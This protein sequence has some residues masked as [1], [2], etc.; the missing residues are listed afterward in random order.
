MAET[1]QVTLNSFRKFLE[2]F[3]PPGRLQNNT[4]P[5]YSCACPEGCNDAPKFPDIF[6]DLAYCVSFYVNAAVIPASAKIA[7][8]VTKGGLRFTVKVLRIYTSFVG[9]RDH[10]ISPNIPPH[11]S[12]PN[13]S[14]S[15]TNPQN[16][17]GQ[18]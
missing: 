3:V 14:A 10:E 16:V 7:R 8:L 2:L 1:L 5:N 4:F 9:N 11:F 12:Q 18:W 17:S 6:E 13:L 15:L